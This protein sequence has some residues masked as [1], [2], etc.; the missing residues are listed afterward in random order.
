MF[1]VLTAFFRILLF[2]FMELLTGGKQ[3]EKTSLIDEFN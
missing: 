2:S 1:H 3:I